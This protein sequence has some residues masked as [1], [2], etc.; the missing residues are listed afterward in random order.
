MSSY[1]FWQR[2]KERES[3][4]GDVSSVDIFYLVTYMSAIAA[5]G[6]S[7][8]QIFELASKLPCASSQ[9]IRKVHLMVHGLGY[10]YGVACRLVGESTPVAAMKSFML[11]IAGAL[12]SGEMGADFL[13]GE[14]QIQ[15]AAYE[16]EYERDVDS[17]RKWTDAY[18]AL[19]VS[20]TL[21]VIINLISTMIYEA[22]DRATIG[23]TFLALL[24]GLSGAWIISRSA[25]KEMDSLP[26]SE[27]S[28]EDKLARKLLKILVPVALVV[29]LG[30]ALLKAQLGLLFIAG[31]VLLF[32]I[33]LVN[34]LGQ[35]KATGKEQEIGSLL[36]TMG[37]MATSLGTTLAEAATRIDLRSF[38]ALRPDLERLRLRLLGFV[39]FDVCW[40][41]FIAEAGSA[42]IG[43]SGGIFHDS[44]AMGGDPDREGFLCSLFASKV[45]ML[46][47][48][49]GTVSSTFV[50]L[51]FV[52]HLVVMALMVFIMEIVLGFQAVL[53]EQALGIG[54]DLPL[55]IFTFGSKSTEFL[56]TM[57]KATIFLLTVTPALALTTCKGGNRNS[58]FHYFGILLVIS[59]LALLGVPKL[60]R[61][62]FEGVVR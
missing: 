47:A 1:R 61:P 18:S 6:I 37:G 10:D 32:P 9:Y 7:R 16:N 2:R 43:Q 13:A 21:V 20:V 38:A 17:M 58:F 29:C 56:Y 31:G 36:R 4:S 28:S 40:K 15:G 27:G 53:Q 59:G 33:G 57:T 3:S 34:S 50:W 39:T 22:G 23:I 60:A 52:M 54:A 8:R 12:N 5:A 42:L 19:T 11:R 49:R 24:I 62:I 41:R 46:R 44:V 55:P 51:S 14:A 48:K 35:R 26:S 45:S 25:P 30:L